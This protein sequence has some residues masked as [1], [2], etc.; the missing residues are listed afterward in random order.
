MV[1][2]STIPLKFFAEFYTLVT[3]L[4]IEACTCSWGLQ[5]CNQTLELPLHVVSKFYQKHL[6]RW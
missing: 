1:R 6:K 4:K 2:L 3:T 5:F